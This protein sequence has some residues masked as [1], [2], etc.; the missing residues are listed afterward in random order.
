MLDDLLAD[1]ARIT[2]APQAPG[3][4]DR[5]E[6]VVERIAHIDEPESIDGLLRLVDP[7]LPYELCYSIVHTVERFPDETY[8][9]HLLAALPLLYGRDP[10]WAG[11][12]VR[13]VINAPGSRALLAGLRPDLPP[14]QAGTLRAV[15]RNLSADDPPP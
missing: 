4:V 7:R 1:L 6:E 3:F 2:A 5:F 11:I 9:P 14:D 10:E 13:R 15:L 8:L 12:L